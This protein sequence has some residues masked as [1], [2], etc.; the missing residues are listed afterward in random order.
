MMTLQEEEGTQSQLLIG[1][2][3]ISLNV[4]F[5]NMRQQ[6]VGDGESIL[7]EISFL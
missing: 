2:L 1:V 3:E 5:F 7:L 4:I 6:H